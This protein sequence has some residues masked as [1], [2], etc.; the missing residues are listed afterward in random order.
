MTMMTMTVH[1]WAI[2]IVSQGFTAVLSESIT[3]RNATLK[4]Q[5][6]YMWLNQCHLH[7]QDKTNPR[8]GEGFTPEAISCTSQTIAVL[9]TIKSRTKPTVCK[10][11][12][13]NRDVWTWN[14]S[15]M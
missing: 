1:L 7:M 9:K 13:H 5:M 11:R 2:S 15:M 12:G 4:Q 8:Q 6:C 3:Y 10:G 14:E